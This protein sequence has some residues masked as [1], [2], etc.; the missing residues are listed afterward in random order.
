MGENC[1]NKLYGAFAFCIYDLKKFAFL[2]EID[3]VKN[4]YFF[5][6]NKGCLFSSEIK[7]FKIFGYENKMDLTTLAKIFAECTKN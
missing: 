7:F 5:G 6:K 3:L 4:L 1:L 2:Q